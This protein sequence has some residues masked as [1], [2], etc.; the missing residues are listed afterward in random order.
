MEVPAVLAD[1]AL[2]TALYVYW[3]EQRH[4]HELPDRRDIDPVAIP[5]T[6]L[7]HL[8]LVDVVDGGARFRNRLVGTAIVERWG[9]DTTGRYHDELMSPGSYSDYIHSLYRE[10]VH[11]RAPVYSESLFRWDVHG[12]LLTRRLYLPLTFG[13]H[14]VAMVLVGQTFRGASVSGEA[15]RTI[16]DHAVVEQRRRDVLVAE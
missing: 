14:P 15:Y 11:K 9:A 2:L 1:D 13:G 5:T 8:A 16:F 7:P 10:T 12:H 4:G 6:L 3:A